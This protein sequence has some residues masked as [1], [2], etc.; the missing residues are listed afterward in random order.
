MKRV[1]LVLLGGVSTITWTLMGLPPI[2]YVFRYGLAPGC[3]PTGRE[4][5]IEGIEFVEIGPGIFRMGSEHLAEGGAVR[6]GPGSPDPR[7]RAMV[8]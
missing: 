1:L 6:V 7:F 8:R 4:M 2:R 3:E 5:T